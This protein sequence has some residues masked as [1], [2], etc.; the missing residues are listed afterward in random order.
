MHA[1]LL[2]VWLLFPLEDLNGEVLSGLPDLALNVQVICK[3]LLSQCYYV[4]TRP[5]AELD[6]EDEGA[7]LLPSLTLAKNGFTVWDCVSY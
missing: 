4:F 5:D 7:Y 1:T 2:A 3:F 6:H